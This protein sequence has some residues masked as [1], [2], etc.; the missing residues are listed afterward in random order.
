[1]IRR[2][3]AVFCGWVVDSFTAC[4]TGIHRLFIEPQQETT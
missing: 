4:M 2:P 1:M 3:I